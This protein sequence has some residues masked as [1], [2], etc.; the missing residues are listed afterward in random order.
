MHLVQWWILI[1]LIKH[2]TKKISDQNSTNNYV[3]TYDELCTHIFDSM[4]LRQQ[5]Q[6]FDSAPAFVHVCSSSRCEEVYNFDER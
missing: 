4:L 1:T 2:Y 5:I 3:S 6:A